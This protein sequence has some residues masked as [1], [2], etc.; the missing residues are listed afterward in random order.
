MRPE[1][2][3]RVTAMSENFMAMCVDVARGAYFVCSKILP[4]ADQ[5]SRISECK[6]PA[7][8][9]RQVQTSLLFSSTSNS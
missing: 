6:S 1:M 4:R 7:E 9:T 3:A 8:E 5:Q 2:A